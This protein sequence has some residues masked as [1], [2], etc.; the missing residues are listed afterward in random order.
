MAEPVVIEYVGLAPSSLSDESKKRLEA[1][2]EAANRDNKLLGVR[3]FPNFDVVGE[4]LPSGVVAIYSPDARVDAT[5]LSD[6][7][8]QVMAVTKILPP[9]TAEPDAYFANKLTA[10]QGA[11][12][13]TP[14]QDQTVREAIRK[15]IS[16]KERQPWAPQLGGR[17][18]FAG[19]YSCVQDGDTRNKDYF[20]VARATI[21]D[22]V[23]DFKREVAV[24]QPTY[25][26]LIYGDQVHFGKNVARRNVYRILSNLAEACEVGIVRMDDLLAKLPNPDCAPCEMAVP[27][28]EHMSHSITNVEY[29]GKPAVAVSYGVVPANEC[30]AD[31]HFFVVANPYDGISRF[32]LSNHEDIK[33]AIG[34]PMDTGRKVAPAQLMGAQV[35]PE[36]M[37]GV[38]WEKSTKQHHPDLHQDA[39][40]PLGKEFKLAMRD[41]GWNPEHHVDRLVPIA[42]KISSPE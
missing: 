7:L 38:T 12:D 32:P 42:I 10:I 2:V 20:L 22:Y 33:A 18:A 34:L 3:V 1:F 23:N 8:F 19:I 13:Q 31:E 30:L 17:G 37:K 11:V 41:M 4:E 29:N 6:D 35:P 14:P 16:N 9:S 36:R 5:L 40:R 39:F 26:D 15:P 28:W 27:D 21:P 25:R 24:K